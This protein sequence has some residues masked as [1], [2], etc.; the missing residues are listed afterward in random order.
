M[1]QRFS[2]I[3]SV[4]ACL[5]ALA[6]LT[7][8]AS[9]AAADLS[10]F[11]GEYK[12]SAEVISADGTKAMRDMNVMIKTKNKREFTVDWTS[13]TYRPDGRTKSKS[14]SINFE[15][16]SRP[17]VFAAA[18]RQDLFGNAVQLNPMKGEPYVW[19]RVKGDTLTIYSL[20][21]DSEGGYD[22]QQFDR[23]LADGGLELAFHSIHN[24]MILR[25]VRTFLEKQ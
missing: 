17:G 7:F 21:I 19:G 3:S 10:R 11:D 20:Y 1:R 2:A 4:A 22:L 8:S 6:A 23:T 9:A 13:T 12:G 25:T 24:G 5:L 15:S 16:T 18:M 14:Y